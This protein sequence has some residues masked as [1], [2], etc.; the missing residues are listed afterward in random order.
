MFG[1]QSCNGK[2]VADWYGGFGFRI[3]AISATIHEISYSPNPPGYP[4]YPDTTEFGVSL[5]PFVN[6]GLRLGF[7]L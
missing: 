6:F 4:K 1:R 3:T 5:W 2:F 7:E